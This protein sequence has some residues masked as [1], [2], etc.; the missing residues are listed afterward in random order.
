MNLLMANQIMITVPGDLTVKVGQIIQIDA[1]VNLGERVD[2]K[3]FHGKWLIYGINHIM[4]AGS[5]VMKLLLC[6]DSNNKI[7]SSI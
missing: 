5:H 1:S 6:R 3:R 2:F 4:I 7:I